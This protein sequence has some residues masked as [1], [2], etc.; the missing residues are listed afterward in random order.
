M[1]SKFHGIKIPGQYGKCIREG[2]PCE[3][4]QAAIKKEE[5]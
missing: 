5:A 3:A 4:G 1:R 2:G